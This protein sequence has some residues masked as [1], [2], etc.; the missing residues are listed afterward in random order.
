MKLTMRD[1]RLQAMRGNLDAGVLK[2]DEPAEVP[3]PEPVVQK[4]VPVAAPVTIDMEP[5]A[6]AVQQAGQIQAQMLGQVAQMLKAEPAA[7]PATKWTFRITER[8]R[9]G[10]IISF[11]AEA[12]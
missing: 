4:E 8:D 12:S 11:T 2:K 10:N 7:K 6:Y 3:K 5:V 1:A 9:M